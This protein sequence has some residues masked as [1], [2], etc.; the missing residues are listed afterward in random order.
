M[1]PVRQLPIVQTLAMYL[2]GI[3]YPGI[4]DSGSVPLFSLLLCEMTVLTFIP[5]IWL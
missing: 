1:V 4:C 3:K 5:S 2:L